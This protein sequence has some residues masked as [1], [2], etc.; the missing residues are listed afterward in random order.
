MK[1]IGWGVAGKRLYQTYGPD[2]LEVI[3][4]G[5]LPKIELP[6]TNID[7]E[8]TQAFKTLEVNLKK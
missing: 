4:T 6:Q 7:E 3:D 1:Q 2:V 5:I 8:F